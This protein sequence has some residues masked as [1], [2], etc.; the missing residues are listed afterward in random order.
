MSQN[1]AGETVVTVTGPAEAE[2][3]E[4]EPEVKP[5]PKRPEVTP[6]D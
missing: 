3:G 6:A 5:E 4:A 2:S 1:E